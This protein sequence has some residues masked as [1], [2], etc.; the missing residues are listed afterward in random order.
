MNNLMLYTYAF[1][2]L[3]IIAMTVWGA[4][5]LCRVGHLLLRETLHSDQDVAGVVNH[6]LS[7]GFYL[8]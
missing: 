7:V 6:L 2:G 5:A 1:Y 8:L 4:H 3:A